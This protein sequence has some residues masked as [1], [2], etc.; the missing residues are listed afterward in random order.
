M[1]TVRKLLAAQRP[2]NL[3]SVK[4]AWPINPEALTAEQSWIMSFNLELQETFLKMSEPKKSQLEQL[5]KQ[6][7]EEVLEN[8]WPLRN[9]ERSPEEMEVGLR[10]LSASITHYLKWHMDYHEAENQK[11]KEVHRYAITTL[12]K[13]LYNSNRYTEV[14]RVMEACHPEYDGF[15]EVILAKRW[16]GVSMLKVGTQELSDIQKTQLEERKNARKWIKEGRKLL[17][18]STNLTI[19][20]SLSLMVAYDALGNLNPS[21][22][23]II[24]TSI[25]RWGEALSS[26]AEQSGVPLPRHYWEI[27]HKHYAL[28]KKWTAL[29]THI[30]TNTDEHQQ[31]L[32]QIN[33]ALRWRNMPDR[34]MILAKAL[35]TLDHDDPMIGMILKDRDSKKIK[36]QLHN[37]LKEEAYWSANSDLIPAFAIWE[38]VSY[39]SGQPHSNEASLVTLSCGDKVLVTEITESQSGC[40]SKLKL[41]C[42]C[43][44]GVVKQLANEKAQQDTLDKKVIELW[45]EYTRN[46]VDNIACQA[47]ILATADLF[48]QGQYS[49]MDLEGAVFGELLKIIEGAKKVS[50]LAWLDRRIETTKRQVKDK[51]NQ[52]IKE[53][54]N[55]AALGISKLSQPR[56]D[57]V[58]TLFI[59]EDSKEICFNE[60]LKRGDIQFVIT[61]FSDQKV[62]ESLDGHPITYPWIK[63]LLSV[64]FDRVLTEFPSY[65]DMFQGAL[66]R[67]LKNC[68]TLN[69]AHLTKIEEK[70]LIVSCNALTE[71]QWLEVLETPFFSVTS[72]A[73]FEP[74]VTTLIVRAEQE[75]KWNVLTKLM[76]TQLPKLCSLL[77]K[78]KQWEWIVKVAKPRAVL[79]EASQSYPSAAEQIC[80]MPDWNNRHWQQLFGWIEHSKHTELI[81]I[82]LATGAE[83]KEALGVRILKIIS[84]LPEATLSRYLGF[85]TCP[86]ETTW[87]I[88]C[89]R[90][91]NVQLVNQCLDRNPGHLPLKRCVDQL[92]EG[93]NCEKLDQIVDSIRVRIVP[94][95]YNGQLTLSKQSLQLIRDICADIDQKITKLELSPLVLSE[96]ITWK[97][98]LQRLLACESFEFVT[99]EIQIPTPLIAT[100]TGDSFLTKTTSGMTQDP[101]ES[102]QLFKQFITFLK[103]EV[104]KPDSPMMD[105][106]VNL[107]SIKQLDK[108]LFQ[109]SEFLTELQKLRSCFVYKA[110]CEMQKE[111]LLRVISPALLASLRTII[112]G[113]QNRSEF[114]LAS[115]P[116]FSTP[117]PDNFNDLLSKV[118]MTPAT[119]FNIPIFKQAILKSADYQLAQN[120]L[121]KQCWEG[122][123]SQGIAVVPSG[124][125]AE[126]DYPS[127]LSASVLV[128]Q[129]NQVKVIHINSA[130]GLE[131]HASHSKKQ[132]TSHDG[133]PLLMAAKTR[134]LPY[135]TQ[136]TD[137]P[138]E[139]PI[140]FDYL[141]ATQWADRPKTEAHFKP[142]HFYETIWPMIGGGVADISESTLEERTKT[143]ARAMTTPIKLLKTMA[144]L[145]IMQPEWLGASPQEEPNIKEVK[146]RR[147][148]YKRVIS[149]FDLWVGSHYLRSLTNA[150]KEGQY[151]QALLATELSHKVASNCLKQLTAESPSSPH[152]TFLIFQSQKLAA[153]LSQKASELL[154]MSKTDHSE[155]KAESRPPI[156]A[157]THFVLP[158][159]TIPK[160]TIEKIPPA[161]ISLCPKISRDTFENWGTVAQY[162]ESIE[163]YLEI[164]SKDSDSRRIG[165]TIETI[166]TIIPAYWKWKTSLIQELSPDEIFKIERSLKKLIE[167]YYQAGLQ[168]QVIT[169][170]KELDPIEYSKQLVTAYTL[171][172]ISDQC[173]R[174]DPRLYKAN[175][176]YMPIDGISGHGHTAKVLLES[177]TLSDP[178]W[179]AA[180][181]SLKE[182]LIQMTNERTPLFT[183][184]VDHC[185]LQMKIGEEAE[186]PIMT[187]SQDI[188]SQNPVW[189]SAFEKRVHGMD[190]AEQKTTL[191]IGSGIPM[192]SVWQLASQHAL[193]VGHRKE[194]P[195]YT[196]SQ[197]LTLDWHQN[198][199]QVGN[200]PF[201]ILVPI[202]QWT[203]SKKKEIAN[204][205]QLVPIDYQ[206]L[207]PSI[208][209]TENEVLVA[210]RTH[211]PPL[212]ISEFRKLL[213]LAASHNDQLIERI[214]THIQEDVLNIENTHHRQ[215]IRQLLY[216]NGRSQELIQTISNSQ[217]QL[218][219]G[220]CQLLEK[221]LQILMSKSDADTIQFI[222]ELAIVLTNKRLAIM[223]RRYLIQMAQSDSAIS[224]KKSAEIAAKLIISYESQ[225][226]LS[227]DELSIIVTAMTLFT[228]WINLGFPIN[229]SH[230]MKVGKVMTHLGNA[231]QTGVSEDP[232]VLNEVI[233]IR[234]KAR[235][236]SGPWVQNQSTKLWHHDELILNPLTGEIWQNGILIGALPSQI[237]EH[238][239]YLDYFGSHKFEVVA[240]ETG[241]QT[242]GD[243]VVYYFELATP[244]R[245]IDDSRYGQISID[246]IMARPL[247]SHQIDDDAKA[248]NDILVTLHRVGPKDGHPYTLFK[249]KT[250]EFI[251]Q[252]KPDWGEAWTHKR[253]RYY[254]KATVT[255]QDGVEIIQLKQW[256]DDLIEMPIYT[257]NPL[258]M[259]G[260]LSQK[261]MSIDI[262]NGV[263]EYIRKAIPDQDLH[264]SIKKGKQS[265]LPDWVMRSMLPG[266]IHEYPAQPHHYW[267]DAEGHIHITPAGSDD[268]RL[269]LTKRPEG[270]QLAETDKQPIENIERMT[271]LCRI[272]NPNYIVVTAE[273]CSLPRFG[274]NFTTNEDGQ[275]L[276]KELEGF[277]VDTNANGNMLNGFSHYLV[278]YHFQNPSMIKLIVPHVDLKQ[279]NGDEKLAHSLVMANFNQVKSAKYLVIDYD[280]VTKRFSSESTLGKLTMAFLSMATATLVKSPMTQLNGYEL[281]ADLLSNCRQNRPFTLDEYDCLHAI[282]ATHDQHRNAHALRL[283]VVSLL[284]ESTSLPSFYNHY[285]YPQKDMT[286][287]VAADYQSYLSKQQ[288]IDEMCRLSKDQLALIQSDY[289][290]KHKSTSDLDT[291]IAGVVASIQFEEAIKGVKNL[292]NTPFEAHPKFWGW[293]LHGTKVETIFISI[294]TAIKTGDLSKEDAEYA[295]RYLWCDARKNKSKVST[296]LMSMLLIINQN[297]DIIDLQIPDI[298]DLYPID[299]SA[300][301][302]E[303]G[304]LSKEALLQNNHWACLM[305]DLAKLCDQL[306]ASIEVKTAYQA[307]HISSEIPYVATLTTETPLKGVPASEVTQSYSDVIKK[308]IKIVNPAKEESDIDS[309]L[310]ADHPKQW[311][312]VTTETSK[313][314]PYPLDSLR[315]HTGIEGKRHTQLQ[316]SW[317]A[318]GRLSQTTYRYDKE[319]V[320][321]RLSERV[322]QWTIATTHLENWIISIINQVPDNIQGWQFLVA[323]LQGKRP[324]TTRDQLKLLKDPSQ[325]DVLNPFLMDSNGMISTTLT[326]AIREYALMASHCQHLKRNIQLIS[327]QPK[328][329]PEAI[330]QWQ[331]FIGESLVHERSF[332]HEEFPE[333]LLFEVDNNLLIRQKQDQLSETLIQANKLLAKMNMGEGKSS[334]VML[335]MILGFA[336]QQKLTRI[337]VP[338]SLITDMETLIKTRLG[339]F[340]TQVYLFPFHRN[341]KKTLLDEA[342]DMTELDQILKQ[343]HYCKQNNHVILMSPEQVQSLHLTIQEL[344]IE[345]ESISD[346][347][348]QY[349]KLT[350]Q[351]ERLRKIETLIEA[352][353]LDEADMALSLNSEFNYSLGKREKIDGGS[354]RTEVTIEWIRQLI[355]PDD[356]ITKIL[357]KT[358]KFL[359]IEGG[360]T[361]QLLMASPEAYTLKL[362]QTL[363]KKLLA[364]FLPNLPQTKALMTFILEGG[365]IDLPKD[366]LEIV[367]S[368]RC[369][370]HPNIAGYVFGERFNVDYG[371][372]HH[373]QDASQAMMAIPYKAKDAPIPNSQF[374]HTDVQLGFTILSYFYKG[375]TQDQV[376]LV[377]EHQ[378]KQVFERQDQFLKWRETSRNPHPFTDWK[379]V[380]LQDPSHIAQLTDSL[381]HHP[382][383]IT[384]YLRHKVFSEHKEF[385][386]KIGSD[387]AR[388]SQLPFVGFSG[389]STQALPLGVVT[390]LPIEESS[391]DQFLAT[392]AQTLAL[393]ADP[394]VITVSPVHF[395]GNSEELL[396]HLIMTCD[397]SDTMR[398]FLDPGAIVTGLTNQQVACELLKKCQSRA[399]KIKYEGVI[400]F[401]DKTDEVMVAR[402]HGRGEICIPYASSKISPEKLLTYFNDIKTRGTDRK[403]PI[404]SAAVLTIGKGMTQEKL[405]QAAMRLRQLGKG[406]TLQL[407]IPD[408]VASDITAFKKKRGQ[409]STQ[410]SP[411]DVYAWA[412]HNT[413]KKEEL[414]LLSQQKRQDR[415]VT[416][417]RLVLTE[418]SKIPPS[419]TIETSG[420]SLKVYDH[421]TFDSQIDQRTQIQVQTQT[422]AQTQS[423]IQHGITKAVTEYQWKYEDILTLNW[424]DNP[425][426]LSDDVTDQIKTQ[427]I[428]EQLPQEV[429][430]RLPESHLLKRVHMSQNFLVTAAGKSSESIRPVEA[431]L[432]TTDSNGVLNII[433]LSGSEAA[434]IKKILL[435]PKGKAC[436]FHRVLRQLS[437]PIGPTVVTSGGVTSTQ[438]NEDPRSMLVLCALING[439]TCLRH[440]VIGDA[441]GESQYHIKI[442]FKDVIKSC[443]TAQQG[444]HGDSLEEAMKQW[445]KT[446]KTYHGKQVKQLDQVSEA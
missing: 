142:E 334:V 45:R 295:I 202:Q 368:I 130:S 76:N 250:G 299:I 330:R 391:K 126:T 55:D 159:L 274:L 206:E 31:W 39:H 257:K 256:G 340:E 289:S 321:S 47:Q 240:S 49:M 414:I 91:E 21:N 342:E 131:Y 290:V 25:I 273:K 75:K 309:E 200:T 327:H 7:L 332:L 371:L 86:E 54:P 417:Y 217:P 29:N 307:P 108:T 362:R 99:Q 46:P 388:L 263:Q 399:L 444:D 167:L 320:L 402:R 383:V 316:E 84:T 124:K 357:Q 216:Q 286:E 363:A 345:R 293:G 89:I 252:S 372:P 300:L 427:S 113:Y 302:D 23:K 148:Q 6:V 180:L 276:S 190:T 424:F 187:V 310:Q 397:Q 225:Q 183:N 158:P 237:T 318:K 319:T 341:S 352:N 285:Q 97:I 322:A 144:F 197:T 24:S 92:V 168:K 79:F 184:E 191:V 13:I 59:T 422:Q 408:Y 215:L 107:E 432:E 315:V 68:Q 308:I 365:E 258:K 221:K 133:K 71:T 120:E 227:R 135:I 266:F 251:L 198:P 358:P 298:N 220:V 420:I 178:E 149:V 102:V 386:K 12:A 186:A 1:M 272:E 88:E 95:Q 229:A 170:K 410:L 382:D 213:I 329:N 163:K 278:L 328:S 214:Y 224:E 436:Q 116:F 434:E 78:H 5:S 337:I 85:A 82:Y 173:V 376:K 8:F 331:Q 373:V 401:D 409:S 249:S 395:N 177:A 433:L 117:S 106:K 228:K 348:E 446:Q 64:N 325:L 406:Q 69:S 323:K 61:N 416:A 355:C 134:Y 3:H 305:M 312:T 26:Q 37:Q 324:V 390:E 398:A 364:H 405:V 172:A 103:L 209:A 343:V 207:F 185:I 254:F 22:K 210:K 351:I 199:R 403:L 72:F 350:G 211:Q 147:L 445:I 114:A 369:W 74:L 246:G 223:A 201:T 344:L 138:K 73:R 150:D 98:Q 333:K 396:T 261:D 53:S 326:K 16:Q 425:N 244:K 242:V 366:Q 314:S 20:E 361:V 56:F 80:Q 241:Y 160:A 393:F 297:R 356:E 304:I 377:L 338:E 14:I 335:L 101:L 288:R 192:M 296:T 109:Y 212:P 58:W 121:L 233:S 226:D 175:G 442:L 438:L 306:K 67:A 431:Y 430:S 413:A 271:H 267:K 264:I 384:H 62:K 132:M 415:A 52:W 441:L 40:Q 440:D 379:M 145:H 30:K 153:G 127:D 11:V 182:S 87:T 275:F 218:I 181:H 152:L 136:T 370:M 155:E 247:K 253:Y 238:P 260:A 354:S 151:T 222:A 50:Q 171:L 122:L 63:I 146:E 139:M 303:S 392:D 394:T 236:I 188:L 381:S 419:S 100:A 359:K 51:I 19:E 94:T 157:N 137:C 245:K 90:I 284:I 189:K 18:K 262:Q 104:A 259:R 287:W 93:G 292:G 230:E 439:D 429:A 115:H 28:Q 9:D 110:A 353:V 347:S 283:I 380:N 282:L 280:S 385:T 193:I 234:F 154:A 291:E 418:D 81:D 43:C 123:H 176:F 374:E 143:Q 111:E 204:F 10:Q 161:A 387:G 195:L 248:I 389:T 277:V 378:F 208:H 32:D 44:K 360:N 70:L 346:E 194:S 426:P 166:E 196:A 42:P 35:I 421:P 33:L 125:W 317:E 294:L 4:Y 128:K 162:L 231:I 165:L 36:H 437:D 48:Y 268:S 119:L 435:S 34:T 118:K 404:N 423:Q 311:I 255:P 270:Y 203:T 313:L 60:A 179:I 443:T 15:N 243:G 367:R 140:W 164:H 27:I 57:L 174:Q 105:I 400:Y 239:D 2:S 17:E 349:Q 112:S 169:G 141:G 65:I 265:A 66:I 279:H 412:V 269:T 129:G 301:S 281:A 339:L 407:W 232:Q 411:L 41:E 205:K 96:L 156:K 38:T 235:S 77:A 336:K 219:D 428:A 375:L 83:T